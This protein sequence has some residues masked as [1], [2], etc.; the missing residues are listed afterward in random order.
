M[1]EWAKAS[2]SGVFAFGNEFESRPGFLFVFFFSLLKSKIVHFM[3]IRFIMKH[4]VRLAQWIE[5][6]I[7]IEAMRDRIPSE[8]FLFLEFFSYA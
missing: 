7:S 5:R 3:L 4:E 8:Q 1:A 2:A 6:D